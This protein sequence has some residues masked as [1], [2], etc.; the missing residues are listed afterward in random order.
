ML[1]L[2]CLKLV[3]MKN[4]FNRAKVF[5]LMLFKMVINQTEICHQMFG[6]WEVQTMW[7]VWVNKLIFTNGF[8]WSFSFRARD[9]K[10]FMEWNLTDSPVKK[11]FLMQ[12]LVKMLMLSIFWNIK[13][14]ITV[15]SGRVRSG[16]TL[17]FSS[18][19]SFL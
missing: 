3:Y 10:R 14:L 19:W 1:T 7:K 17:F 18:C 5:V 6:G 15:C 4:H 2:Y 12:W 13:G 9:K 11:Y 16:G 8:N